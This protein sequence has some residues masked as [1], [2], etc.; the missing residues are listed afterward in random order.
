MDGCDSYCACWSLISPC[1]CNVFSVTVGSAL[2]MEHQTHTSIFTGI[3]EGKTVGEIVL[4]L[5]FM[6]VFHPKLHGLKF[7]LL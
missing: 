7:C 4:T 2:Q 6:A 3:M 5:S 1:K